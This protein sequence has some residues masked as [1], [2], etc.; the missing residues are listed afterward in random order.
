MSILSTRAE[1]DQTPTYLELIRAAEPLH[2]M[3][4]KHFDPHTAIIVQQDSVRVFK[5][6]MGAVLPIPD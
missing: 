2:E 1:A 6:T 4:C 3:L 5:S